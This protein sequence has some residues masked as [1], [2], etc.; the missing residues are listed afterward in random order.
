MAGIYNVAGQ[1]IDQVYLTA[2]Q[3]T[4]N[5]N[6]QPAGMYFITAH[7]QNGFATGKVIIVK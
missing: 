6:N 4:L 7:T 1:K 2:G 3:N 5:L